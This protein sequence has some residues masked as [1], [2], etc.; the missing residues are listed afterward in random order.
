MNMT[1]WMAIGLGLGAL[2]GTAWDN[3]PIGIAIGIG[4]AVI[5]GGIVS[6][7][8]GRRKD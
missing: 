2:A 3:V 4:V 5:V 1:L 7:I 8:R 6:A